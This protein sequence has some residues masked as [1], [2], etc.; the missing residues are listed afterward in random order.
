MRQEGARPDEVVARIAARQHGVVDF[1]QLLFAG[2]TPSSITRRVKAGHLHRVYR[3]V[4]A[5]GHANLSREGR[6]TAAVRACGAGALL[7][8]ESAAA[9]WG[10]SPRSPSLVHVTVPNHNGRRK[11][12]GIRIHYSSTLTRKDAA[13]RRNIPVTALARTLQDLGYGPEPTRSDLERAFL[14]LCR[15]D[16]IPKPETNVRVGPHTVDFL[17][18]DAGLVVEV[19]GYSY[20]SDPATF[21]S[22]RR[23]DREL[24]KRGIDVL[25]FAGREL[26]REGDAVSA[27]VQGHLR[28]RLGGQ[29]E[30]GSST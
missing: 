2:L 22:D 21:E 15:R 24:K 23:R 30:A 4:Y 6:W 5:V 13:R 1:G 8:H 25:R 10:I 27:S 18:R 29:E 9:L 17:W 7:S 28:P 16:G 3:G 20:H 14:R 12:S 26:A 11:R 19:D